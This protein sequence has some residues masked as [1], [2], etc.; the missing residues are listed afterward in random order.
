MGRARLLTALL[1]ATLVLPL[2]SGCSTAKKKKLQATYGPS[3]SILEVVAVLRR[4]VPDDTY[5]FPPARDF[6]GRN[7]YRSSLLR[8]EN[9]ERIHTDALASGYMD[10][11]IG[12]AKGRALE[13][14]RAY[15]LAAQHYRE[16]A[17]RGSDLAEPARRS[18]SVCERIHG[19]VQVG[20]DIDDPLEAFEKGSLAMSIRVDEEIALLEERVA[21]LSLLLEEVRGTHYAPVVLEEIERAD[22][23]RTDYVLRIRYVL[24]NGQIRALGE[25]QRTLSRHAASKRRLRHTLDLAVF[26]DE[27][28]HEYVA[29]IKPEG[30][31]FDPARFEELVDPATQLYQSVATEDGTPEKLEASRRLEAFLAFRLQVD[32]DRFSQ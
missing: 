1:L 7:V 19:A 9:I 24:P 30:L 21:L 20:M 10:D 31:R 27:L 4:H 11:V 23:I 2:A 32:G 15:D 29:A 5:R 8:L 16:V 3:E 14:L 6:T 25:L 26:Y 22:E 12:F 28:A 18:A 13:R 17:V